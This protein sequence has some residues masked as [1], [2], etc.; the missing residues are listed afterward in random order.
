[1]LLSVH[2]TSYMNEP[3]DRDI[4]GI[5]FRIH[6]WGNFGIRADITVNPIRNELVTFGNDGKRDHSIIKLLNLANQ[7]IVCNPLD[8]VAYHFQAF[9]FPTL[10][11]YTWP[12]SHTCI[13]YIIL[14]MAQLGITTDKFQVF[15][16]CQSMVCALAC[17]LFPVTIVYHTV[18]CCFSYTRT[19]LSFCRC[20]NIVSNRD[21]QIIHILHTTPISFI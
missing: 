20:I 13:L 16:S 3:F 9:V 7:V 14:W 8:S 11:I 1:M 6:R 10:L 18:T 4:P 17:G 12:L 19:V 5:A 15:E 2:F 21:I